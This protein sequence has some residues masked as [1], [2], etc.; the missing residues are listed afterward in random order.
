MTQSLEQQE[1]ITTVRCKER[2]KRQ[3]NRNPGLGS[4]GRSQNQCRPFLWK[5]EPWRKCSYFWRWH[6]K[7]RLLEKI[8]W[9]LPSSHFIISFQDLLLAKP[10]QGPGKWSLQGSALKCRAVQGKR[11][12]MKWIW[13]KQTQDCYNPPPLLFNIHSHPSTHI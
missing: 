8:L 6:L 13:W 2:G 12:W 7:W 3:C 5:L 4:P 10:T 11:V 1:G 9:I